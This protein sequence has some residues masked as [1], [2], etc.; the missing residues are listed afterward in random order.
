MIY[1]SE[2]QGRK[3]NTEDNIFIGLLEDVI[4]LASENPQITKLVIRTPKKEKLIIPIRFLI[5]D[6]GGIVVQKGFISQE[7]EENELSLLKNLLDK[8]IIDLIGNKIV[9]VNDVMIQEK[10][11]Y[12]ISGVDIGF[13]G[14]LRWFKMEKFFW[15]LIGVSGK[16]ITSDFLSWADIQPLE[17]AR[18]TVVLKQ[19]EG[20][21]KKLRPEDLADHLE[22]TNIENVDK[23]L[24]ILDEEFAADV[25]NSLNINY[26]TALFKNFSSDK[27][28]RIL[29]LIDPD[30]AVDILL[31]LLPHRRETIIERLDTATKKQ[32]QHLLRL[33]KS[34]IGEKLTTD[35]L[36]VS[37]DNTVIEVIDKL[38]RETSDFPF[39][40]YIYVV[41]KEKKLIGVFSLHELLLQQS[42]TIVYKFMVPNVIVAHLTTPEEIVIKRMYKYRIQAIPVIDESQQILGIV[43]FDSAAEFMLNIL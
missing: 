25:I 1:F 30:E 23:V 5:K 35:F 39:L 37:P 16:K 12:Y 21:L 42:D 17:L 11:T 6:N 26:Q 40:S 15:K 33:C 14:I 28:A 34:P 29:N 27:A 32:I 36:S 18:G 41:N 9:R 2:L 7:M 8:Q 13:L 24:K 4:F 38:R 10:P 19:K 20:K 43:T 3:V 22:R 31:T